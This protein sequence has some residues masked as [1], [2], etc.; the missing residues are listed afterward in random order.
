MIYANKTRSR[1]LNEMIHSKHLKDRLGPKQF[2][3]I[4]EILLSTNVLR[5][6]LTTRR[7]LEIGE[8]SAE[9][10]S[11]QISFWDS[12]KWMLRGHLCR[13]KSVEK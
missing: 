8:N 9:T 1:S 7:F 13:I 12:F 6:Q 4:Q 3:N 5:R 2:P 10:G 11:K